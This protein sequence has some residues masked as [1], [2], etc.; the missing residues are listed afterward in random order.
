MNR[1]P[2]RWCL[3][4][5]AK[6]V[7]RYVLHS[8]NSPFQTT[9]TTHACF[10]GRVK[11]CARS[12]WFEFRLSLSISRSLCAPNSFT[13][14]CTIFNRY[15]HRLIYAVLV[16]S[17]RVRCSFS[18]SSDREYSSLF[19]IHSLEI[20]IFVR[21]NWYIRPEK[22]LM[23]CTRADW[24]EWSN[25]ENEYKTAKWGRRRDIN[26]KLFYCQLINLP[27]D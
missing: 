5:S 24:G 2:E 11:V 1:D 8:A 19:G 15:R 4:L 20:S 18:L 6:Q 26:R 17:G 22:K 12:L 27:V 23:I 7:N 13:I 9:A 16:W 3:I 10:C 25:W 14:V 21:F